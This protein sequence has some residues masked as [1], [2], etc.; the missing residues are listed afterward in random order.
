MRER[1]LMRADQLMH[2]TKAAVSNNGLGSGLPPPPLANCLV[3]PLDC[4]LILCSFALL[5][6]WVRGRW[7]G[8]A[9]RKRPVAYPWTFPQNRPGAADPGNRRIFPAQPVLKKHWAVEEVRRCSLLLLPHSST[10][11]TTWC[12]FKTGQVQRLWCGSQGQRAIQIGK[13]RWHWMVRWS[14]KKNMSKNSSTTS[15]ASSVSARPSYSTIYYLLSTI[16]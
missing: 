4:C 13:Q 12:F 9:T 10:F 11:S 2:W 8:E 7:K 5:G 6:D 3:P 16:I 1:L 15:D 14:Q